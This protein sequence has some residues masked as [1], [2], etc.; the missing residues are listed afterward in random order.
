MVQVSQTWSSASRLLKL[1]LVEVSS[2]YSLMRELLHT[3]SPVTSV[4]SDTN[5]RVYDK[6]Q[7]AYV[8]SPNCFKRDRDVYMKLSVGEYTVGTSLKFELNGVIISPSIAG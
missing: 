7:L 5:C 2:R 8:N 1:Y 3:E 4:N 6:V